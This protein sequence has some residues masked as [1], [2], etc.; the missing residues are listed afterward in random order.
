MKLPE[1]E[2]LFQTLFWV[3]LFAEEEQN[4]HTKAVVVI[5]TVSFW[6]RRGRVKGQLCGLDLVK[7]FTSFSAAVGGVSLCS[8][9]RRKDKRWDG[10]LTFL[11]SSLV[12]A[13]RERASTRGCK[14]REIYGGIG[15]KRLRELTPDGLLFSVKNETVREHKEGLE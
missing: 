1:E 13:R 12:K 7:R 11:F 14:C 9:M 15:A 4:T 2:F 6:K 8:G 10:G 3:W 5:D